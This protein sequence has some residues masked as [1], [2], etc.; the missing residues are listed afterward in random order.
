MRQVWFICL[1]IVIWASGAIAHEVRPT[2]G[3]LSTSGGVVTLLLDLNVEAFVSGVDLDVAADTN[4]APEAQAYDTLRAL[5]SDALADRFAPVA[6][7]M[8][9]EIGMS[10]DGAALPLR[11]ERVDIGPIGDIEALRDSTLILT[12]DL[13][14]GTTLEV[15]WPRGYG[16]LILRQIDLEDG[17]AGYIDGGSTSGPISIASPTQFSAGS[18]LLSYI[19]VGFEHI[20]PKGLDHILFVLGL[21]FL[22]LRMGALLWQ[23]TAF[24]FAHSVTLALS[25]LGWVSLPGA[26][27]EPIIAASI[28]YV[29][30]EN[31]LSPKMTPWRP[32]V[33]FAFGLLHGLGFASVLGAFGLPEGQVVP[34]LI[35]FNIGVELGQIAVIAMAFGLV[36]YWFGAKPWYRRAIAIPASVIIALIGAWWVVERVFL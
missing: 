3:D 21:F 5:S 18:V 6:E 4:S 17:Y 32:V 16:T 14:R 27:V 24:T 8:A 10:A 29:A 13:E 1:A 7:R 2:V 30:V 20:L 12:A 9:A 36:V 23:V 22:S 31:I 28:V 25:V 33:V 15:T 34:A 26:V 19:A 35:G 11:V